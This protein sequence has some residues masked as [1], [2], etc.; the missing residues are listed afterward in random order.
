VRLLVAVGLVGLA[1]SL[2]VAAP[3]EAAR[4][5]RRPA[6]P[7]LAVV[8]LPFEGKGSGGSDAK[9]A[10]ELELELVEVARVTDGDD[11]EADIRKAGR[12]AWNADVLA[13]ILT[14]RG[15][16]VVVK[17]E[18]GAGERSPDALLVTA[19]GADGQPRFFK[20]LALGTEP[21]VAA[22]TIVGALRPVLDNWEARR[23]VRL[24]GSDDE[25]AWGDRRGRLRAEDVLVDDDRGGKKKKGD[26]AEPA[27]ADPDEDGGGRVVT[28][29][30]LDDDEP[31]PRKVE[32]KKKV[33]DDD[34]PRKK[35]PLDFNEDDPPKKL[36]DDEEDQGPRK[37]KKRRSRLDDDEP[38]K[39]ARADDVDDLGRKVAR[40]DI[41][42]EL[43]APPAAPPSGPHAFSLSAAFDG[44]TW[45]YDLVGLQGIGSR[46]TTAPFFPGGSVFLDA[47]PLAFAGVRWLGVDGD[48]SA[49]VVPFQI[50]G[51]AQ[52]PVTPGEFSVYQFRAGG[53]LKLRYAF[54]SG[55]T[56]GARVGYRYFGAT[57]ENQ[58][59]QAAGRTEL[60]TLVPGFSLH[61]AVV[62]AEVALPLVV[63]GRRLEL[64]LRADGL[65]ATYYSE[66][67]DNPGQTSLAFGWSASALAR[68]E[69]AGGFFVE[70]RGSTVGATVTYTNPGQRNALNNATGELQKLQG[71]SVLNLAAGFSLG[72][73]LMF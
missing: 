13:G 71:G 56:L 27:K 29:S 48:F 55:F 59:V 36:S 19:W 22:A 9:Q 65:P 73:G 52:F 66:A 58:T 35:S 33:V 40:D 46:T 20:E 6:K 23:P 14:K 62:G 24:P 54:S 4:K 39:I 47:A 21:D 53:A 72:L 41:G 60:L 12:K 15:V 61:A 69:I 63:V 64:E 3:A 10:L 50:L 45:Y 17:G 37:K 16:D 5:K 49:S 31:A 43:D 32:P 25:E 8:V 68:M 28:R 38:P 44:S 26:K 18:R 67:P 51:N 2:L 34:P 70:G 42:D 11:V 7:S 57:T 1:F 30:V